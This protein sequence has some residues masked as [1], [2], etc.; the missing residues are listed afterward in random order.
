MIELNLMFHS[1]GFVH[2]IIDEAHWIKYQVK[3]NYKSMKENENSSHK[4]IIS[5][6]R[7]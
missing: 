1:M 4:A 2:D 3:S 6:T 7:N 5:R